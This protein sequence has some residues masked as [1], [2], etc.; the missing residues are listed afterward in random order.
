MPRSSETRRSP[1]DLD[2]PDEKQ[3]PVPSIENMQFDYHYKGGSDCWPI[4]HKYSKVKFGPGLIRKAWAVGLVVLAEI[5]GFPNPVAIK[6]A[7]WTG[8]VFEVKTLD[9]PRIP[10]R[11]FT[12]TSVEGLRSTGEWIDPE[13]VNK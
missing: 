9:G 11:L 13:Q 12:R 4:R 10:S 5:D 7:Q 3:R 2:E 1:T 8:G 6:E